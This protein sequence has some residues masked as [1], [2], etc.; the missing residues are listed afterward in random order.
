MNLMEV[1]VH[2]GLTQDTSGV[3]ANDSTVLVLERFAIRTGPGIGVLV[4]SEPENRFVFMGGPSLHDGSVDNNAVGAQINSPS[5]V[6]TRLLDRVSWVFNQ[7]P[8]VR[9]TG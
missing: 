8:F 6:V 2:D 3:A 4:A 7:T 5:F 9:A 1:L